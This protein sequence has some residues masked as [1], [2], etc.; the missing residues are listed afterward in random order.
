M[1]SSEPHIH[2]RPRAAESKQYPRKRVAIHR[3]NG[4]AYKSAPL[5][6]L[7]ASCPQWHVFQDSAQSTCAASGPVSS[8]RAPNAGPRHSK[9]PRS[10]C[11]LSVLSIL[12][13]AARRAM[14]AA[15]VLLLRINLYPFPDQSIRHSRALL[16]SLSQICQKKRERKKKKGETKEKKTF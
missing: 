12:L 1:H 7:P 9:G 14:A 8:E 16:S 3:P 5:A 13:R 6:P 10:A 11:V 4:F 2:H 15:P